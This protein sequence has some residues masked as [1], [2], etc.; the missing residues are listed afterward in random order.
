VSRKRVL[1]LCTHNSA[2][3][4]MAEGFLRA[5]GGDRF[6]VESAGTEATTVNPFAIQA[7]AEEGIDIA[8]HESKTLDRFVDQPFDLVITVCDDAAEAC[9]VFPNAR[10]R[11]HWSFPDPSKARGT[12]EERFAV[13]ARIRDAIRER[14]EAELLRVRS[15]S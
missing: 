9:P 11:R 13:F 1:F 12:D 15:R 2:R 6:E 7:M 5:L 10:E 3:S 8:T 14:I 4:Q